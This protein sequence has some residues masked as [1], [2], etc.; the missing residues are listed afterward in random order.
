MRP[1]PCY[2]LYFWLLLFILE[3]LAYTYSFVERKW[4]FLLPRETMEEL[5]SIESDSTLDAMEMER[6]IDKILS[7]QPEHILDQLELPLS[8]VNYLSTPNGRSRIDPEGEHSRQHHSRLFDS[9]NALQF[10]VSFTFKLKELKEVLPHE[11]TATIY[12]ALGNNQLDIDKRLAI[13][14]NTMAN[15]P[16]DTL[17]QLF[18][19]GVPIVDAEVRERFRRLWYDRPYWT[20]SSWPIT[21]NNLHS[22]PTPKPATYRSGDKDF[23]AHLCLE[24]VA[25]GVGQSAKEAAQIHLPS[26]IPQT[27]NNP[28]PHDKFTRFIK[29]PQP[30]GDLEVEDAEEV[31]G[32]TKIED[33][34]SSTTLPELEESLVLPMPLPIPAKKKTSGRQEARAKAYGKVRYEQIHE[35]LRLLRDDFR[36]ELPSNDSRVEG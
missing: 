8:T 18:F 10:S 28:P 3:D 30:L 31:G 29:Y 36:K 19:A 27:V 5:G 21:V 9:Y 6:M 34:T 35:L 4:K 2:H 16:F 20:T 7:T 12:E 33:T 15:L 13:I 22:S 32:A 11:H 17:D 1:S 24:C 14:E 23:L 26:L 25:G